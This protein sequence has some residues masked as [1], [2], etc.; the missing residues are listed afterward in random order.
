M[1]IG[2]FVLKFGAG[3]LKYIINKYV[4]CAK[5]ETNRA[6]Y[7]YPFE[8]WQ[9]EKRRDMFIFTLGTIQLLSM[10]RHK[11]DVLKQQQPTTT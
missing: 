11:S 1:K 8:L 6:L 9:R 2:G 3:S 5:Q 10:A 7:L 4:V